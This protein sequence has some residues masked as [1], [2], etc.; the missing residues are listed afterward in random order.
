MNR[1]CAMRAPTGD[2]VGPRRGPKRGLSL[3]GGT[4]LGATLARSGHHLHIAGDA[5][6]VLDALEHR[7]FDLV[8]LDLRAPEIDAISTVK[9]YRYLALGAPQ[10]PIVAVAER[11][12]A[13]DETDCRDAGIES[14]VAPAD[15]VRVMA[16]VSPRGRGTEPAEAG[17][18]GGATV[19]DIAMHK[20]LRAEQRPAPEPQAPAD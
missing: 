17:T 19:F 16:N 14:C 13:E 4:A 11:W 3:V 9:L 1:I 2:A 15:A 18:A 12:R 5:N 7:Q 8:L 6:G 20:R 10:P